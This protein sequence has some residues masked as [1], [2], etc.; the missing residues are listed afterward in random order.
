MGYALIT[1]ASSGLGVEFARLFAADGHSLILV[2][3]RRDRLEALARELTGKHG[4]VKAEVIVMDLSEPGAG[5]KL[6]DAVQAKGHFVEFLVNN[7]GY[8]S[9]GTFWKL[10][11]EKETQMIDVN[12]R[13]LVELTHL[14]LKPMLHTKA[15]AILNIGSTAG[16]QPGPFMATYYASKS[17][18]NLFSQGLSIELEGTGVTCTLLV[19]G[20]TDTE[21]AKV[22]SVEGTV[23]FKTQVMS[24]ADQ[25]A[26]DGY[27]AMM[28]GKRSV[29]S[30]FANRAMI[31]SERFAPMW[32]LLRL[33]AFLNR[34]NPK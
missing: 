20:A 10:P 5:K 33:V 24:A 18:V 11:I 19:P 4:S 1:G 27:R 28:K 9:N 25:V 31:F 14:F 23:M 32:L 12:I 17:F 16:F 2:A 21:F 15:G 7:A 22:A 13:V 8:G 3:R 34:R 6:F 29:V 30:G 26:R